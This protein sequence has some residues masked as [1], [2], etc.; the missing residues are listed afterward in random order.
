MTK[1]LF[2]GFSLF[3]LTSLGPLSAQTGTQQQDPNAGT[4]SGTTAGT[5]SSTTGTAGT[6]GTASVP[7]DQFANKAAQAGLA[8]VE[9][10]GLAS[11]KAESP[12]VKQFA[13][14]MVTDHTQANQQL[15][16]AAPGMNVPDTLD[17]EHQSLKDKLSGLSGKEFDREYM[18]AQVKDHQEA[19]SLFRSE[20]DS[21]QGQLKSFAA[22]MLPKIE[23][24]ARMARDIASKLGVSDVASG[25]DNQSSAS[26]AAAGDMSGS[27]M[28]P[29]TSS[30]TGSETTTSSAQSS[31]STSSSNDPSGT[32]AGGASPERHDSTYD[33]SKEMTNNNLDQWKNDKNSQN[34]STD[35]TARSDTGATSSPGT[36]TGST[37]TDTS[38]TGNTGTAS[39]MGTQ[40]PQSSSSSKSTTS[41][42][43]S[44]MNRADTTGTAGNADTALP[45]T[46]S[47][48][49]L[50]GL[51][52][53]LS[54]ALASILGL[55]RR[56][57]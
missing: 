20:S 12:D 51:L 54:I 47:S 50:I 4:Q 56:M 30:Q 29:N 14:Q 17:A 5:D 33:G 39:S 53:L 10:G 42:T 31:T 34:Q 27:A 44:D 21:G 49:P 6:P 46:A 22:T 11:Q 15:K 40:D 36:T 16:Q 45:R 25:T 8:E 28:N 9:L 3:L 32:T 38:T 24:H 37:A 26:S 2:A 13:Q 57:N 1:R 23:D 55:R 18:R 41:D 43:S 48:L 19:I 7:D 52:G 35:T